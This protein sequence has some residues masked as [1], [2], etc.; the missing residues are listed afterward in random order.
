M[1][2]NTIYIID[3][4]ISVRVRVAPG[5]FARPCAL[6]DIIDLQNKMSTTPPPPSLPSQPEPLVEEL[7]NFFPRMR[8][9]S[10]P[11]PAYTEHVLLTVV[12]ISIFYILYSYMHRSQQVSH[13]YI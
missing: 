13:S 8:L 3:E 5:K 1:H 2:E 7:R 4:L 10:L 9:T 6:R 11:P 12:Y